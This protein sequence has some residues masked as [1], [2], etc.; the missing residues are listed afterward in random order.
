[1]DE[2]QEIP[3]VSN[4]ITPRFNYEDKKDGKDKG[5]SSSDPSEV[6][7]EIQLNLLIGTDRY[8][9]S[10]P[11][12]FI[13]NS[14]VIGGRLVGSAEEI[15]GPLELELDVTDIM[16]PRGIHFLKIVI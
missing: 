1:M 14:K 5:T 12:W 9:F 16:S 3:I 11:A 15:E 2:E 4:W 7:K 8:P 10:Q 6:I 13:K